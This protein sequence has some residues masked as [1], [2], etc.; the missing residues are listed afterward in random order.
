MSSRAQGESGG[1]RLCI[2]LP[3]LSRVGIVLTSRILSTKLIAWEPDNLKFVGVL[4]L[5]LL[6]QLLEPGELRGKAAFRGRV[7]DEDD[8]VLEV[9]EGVGVAFLCL[10]RREVSDA[11]RGFPEMWKGFQCC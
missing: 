6:V 1:R 11:L 9:R 5:Q 10:R 4:C 2:L 7:D 3:S 8:L